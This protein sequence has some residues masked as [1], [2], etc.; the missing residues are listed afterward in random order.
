VPSITADVPPVDLFAFDVSEL[1]SPTDCATRIAASVTIAR[2]AP[3]VGSTRFRV[4]IPNAATS[5]VVVCANLWIENEPVT[6]V[7]E[8]A[9]DSVA[10]V[11]VPGVVSAPVTGTISL[12]GVA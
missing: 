7:V 2:A 6:C 8:P 1:V 5:P 12:P 10:V 9:V 11:E 4:N 3:D